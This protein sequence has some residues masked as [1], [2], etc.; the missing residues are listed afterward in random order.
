M[1]SIEHQSHIDSDTSEALM[2]HS[3]MAHK[4]VDVEKTRSSKHGIM[5]GHYLEIFFASLVL[6]I[7]MT[8]LTIIFM[9]LVYTHLMPNYNSTYSKADQANIPLGSAYY[10]NYSATRLV[11]I[12]SI[13]STLAPFLI[14]A[15]MILFSYPLAHSFTKNSDKDAMSKLPSP[16]Q[17][18]LIIEAVDARLKSLWSMLLYV[19]GSKQ[20]RITVISDLWKSIAML[21]SL[22]VL[23]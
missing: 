15:A 6:I 10:V 18:E 3:K 7:P 19:F 11:F 21:A 1:V 23:A 16:Y 20:K 22:G 8:V 13:S 14:S 9:S 17:L 2:E 4:H 12:S 5:Q